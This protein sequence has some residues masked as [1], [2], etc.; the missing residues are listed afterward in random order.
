MQISP[1][2]EKDNLKEAEQAVERVELHC[3]GLITDDER[4]RKVIGI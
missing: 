2:P 3:R 4:Y 1:S